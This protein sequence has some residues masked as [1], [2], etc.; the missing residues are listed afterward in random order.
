M[1]GYKGNKGGQAE[2]KSEKKVCKKRRK[3]IVCHGK[4]PKDTGGNSERKTFR[5]RTNSEG[6]SFKGTGY[7]GSNLV[8]G[9]HN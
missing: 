1:G 5:R 3:K 2:G 7:R 6:T 8:Q 9:T 4:K